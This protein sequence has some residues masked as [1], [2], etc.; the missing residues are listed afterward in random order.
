MRPSSGVIRLETV[1]DATEYAYYLL[2]PDRAFPVVAVTTAHDG[3][4]YIDADRLADE[5]DGVAEVVV[6]PTGDLTRVIE[7]ILPGKTN[8][9]GGSGRVYPPGS[10]WHEDPYVARLRFC[11]SPE[12][13]GHI[14]GLLLR[15]ARRHAQPRAWT[16]ASSQ[17]RLVRASGVVAML[18]HPDRALVQLDDGTGLVVLYTDRAFPDVKVGRLLRP[19]M[20]VS[21]TLSDDGRILTGDFQRVPAVEALSRVSM[22]DLLPARVTSADAKTAVVSL[23]PGVHTR[24]SRPAGV[25]AGDVVAVLVEA[26]GRADGQGWRLRIE[27]D[28]VP[29]ELDEAPALLPGGPGWLVL[30]DPEPEVEDHHSPAED[31]TTA[32]G[33]H[34]TVEDEPGDDDGDAGP[35]CD[36]PLRLEL[37]RV[38]RELAEANRERAALRED[39][40]R[41]LA[42]LDEIAHENAQLRADLERAR[43]S[44]RA[45]PSKVRHLSSAPTRDD[46]DLFTDLEEQLRF[47]I[48][49]AWARRIPAAD[50]ARLPL[51]EYDIADTFIPSLEETEGVDRSKV[52][53]VV[54]EVLTG[55]A[56]TMPGREL[57]RLRSGPAGSPPIT[58]PELGTA[59]RASI[60]VKTPS[61]RRLH[62]WRGYDGRVTLAQIGLHD[63]MDISA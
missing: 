60:Q 63:D 14:T 52:V 62:F 34:L 38:R 47:E 46:S 43:A 29:D 27:V 19:G 42:E 31:E 11:Y 57:H 17:Q 10:D 25:R 13:G 59:W 15:D 44:R 26:T 51:P 49:L 35:V 41:L 4:L 20:R 55:L 48:Y 23:F 58:H 33:R 18:V 3:R 30:P 56:D 21:G 6:V 53:D 32:G 37:D 39:R 40:G 28:A 61:A 2:S 24:V 16:A 12:E 54:V 45:A 1:E 5:L 22:G 9:F 8:V 7:G 36:T 50:K